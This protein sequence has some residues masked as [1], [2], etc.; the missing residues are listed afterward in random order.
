M[1]G[2]PA[3]ARALLVCGLLAPTAEL[4]AEVEAPL[5]REFGPVAD[6]SED[7]P[8]D[9]TDYYRPEFGAP[10]TRRWLGFHP[11]CSPVLLAAAKLASGAIERALARDG[12]R[13]VNIDPGLLTLHNLVL[14]STKEFAHRIYLRDDIF[15]ELTL[16][17]R[18]G[19][20]EP[21][22][23]TYPD[24]RTRTCLEFL[25]RCRA[26]LLNPAPAPTDWSHN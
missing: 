18:H 25:S 10:L 16:L 15:A 20:W 22:P 17:Y 3:P 8:F 1:P 5:V 23:W 19:A 14:A 13:R 21:L 12:Q 9:F 6:R 24:Y 7:I 2:S 26:R 11:P 4:L